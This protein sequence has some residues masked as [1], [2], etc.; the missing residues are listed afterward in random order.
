M[1]GAPFDSNLPVV[2]IVGPTASGKSDLAQQLALAIDG[3]VVSADS[4]QI[5]RGM[6][7]GTG[8]VMPDERLVPHHGLDLVD[9]GEEYSAA[10]YQE[11]ARS[12]FADI[13]SRGKRPILCGGTGLYVR[14]AIDDYEFPSGGQAENPV[15]AYY[16]AIADEQGVQAVWDMLDAAD[17]ESA[18][19]IHPNNVRRVIRAFELLEEG[20]SYAQQKENLQSIPQKVPAVLFGLRVDRPILV[21]RIYR[22][23]DSMLD[24]GLVDEV[25][26]LLEQGF[27]EGV[28]APQAIGYKEIVAAL[29]GE[30]SLDDAVEEIKIATRRYAK[31]QCSWFNHDERVVWLDATDSSTAELVEQC[32][33]ALNNQGAAR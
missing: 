25:A 1:A 3:E 5:Y 13:C 15:R 8:K 2:C 18:A 21:E 31:R 12:C 20:K 4:M 22:R 23:V 9:P 6:D 19:V 29:D 33:D 27:R 26:G 16:Q 14:A 32:M 10:L 11:Y 28:T 24:A 30:C 17:P 7:I